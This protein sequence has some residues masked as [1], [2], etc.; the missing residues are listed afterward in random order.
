VKDFRALRREYERDGLDEASADTDPYAMFS[1]WMDEAID[2]GLYEPNAMLLATV[3]DEGAPS[4]RLVLL[5]GID[6]RG[7][8]FYTNYDSAKGRDLLTEPRVQVVFPWQEMERQV[9]IDGRAVRLTDAEN[10]AYFASRP[11]SAQLGAWA[12]PQSTVVESRESLTAGLAAAEH[13]FAGV[14]VPRPPLWGGY[15]ISPQHFEFWQG[16]PGRLHDRLRYRKVFDEW[17]RERLAS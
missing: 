16:R 15:R 2:A 17:I 11:R 14:E 1:R 8:V 13:R 9:R 3:D 12:S 6:A 7:L 10:D 5:K 4:V